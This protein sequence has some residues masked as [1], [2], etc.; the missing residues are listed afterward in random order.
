MPKFNELINIDKNSYIPLYVQLSD[1]LAKYIREKSLDE[2]DSIPSE[3]DL[4]RY[5]GISRN[6]VRQAFQILESQDIIHRVRGK[7]TFV[8]R[9]KNKRSLTGLKIIE[10]RLRD[11]GVEVA[12]KTLCIRETFPPGD[13]G[14]LLG[15]APGDKVLLLRR[16]KTANGAPFALEERA[17]PAEVGRKFKTEDLKHQSVNILIDSLPEYKV[18]HVSYTFTSSPLSAVEAKE[19]EVDRSEPVV[20]RMGVYRNR[21]ALPVMFGRLTFLAD[22]IELKFEFVRSDNENWTAIVMS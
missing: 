14:R 4:T 3:N 19:L 20:R 8:T 6:T 5:Y 2:G 18:T 1:I 12:N 13:W 16:V 21:S 11:L 22:R 10:T 15:L 9:S 17:F 7:G